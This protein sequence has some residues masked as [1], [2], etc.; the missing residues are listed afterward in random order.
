MAAAFTAFDH[1]IYQ[2]LISQHVV[3]VFNMPQVLLNYL[4]TQIFGAQPVTGQ[5]SQLFSPQPGEIKSDAN[6]Q[7]ELGK[8]E[9]ANLLPATVTCNRG[10]INPFRALT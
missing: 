5:K 1:P 8:I 7:S 9:Q 6:V 2:R 4:K 10:L 3:D